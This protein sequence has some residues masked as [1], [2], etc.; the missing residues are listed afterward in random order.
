MLQVQT[1]HGK[2]VAGGSV[3][4]GNRV[5]GETLHDQWNIKQVIIVRM[6][7]QQHFDVL[8]I[9]YVIGDTLLIRSNEDRRYARITE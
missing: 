2:D 8:Y 4:V 3:A 5:R 6:A 9:R 1:R 7:N